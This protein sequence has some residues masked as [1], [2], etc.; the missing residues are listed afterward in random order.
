[1]LNEQHRAEARR[2]KLAE[3][4]RMLEQLR[5]EESKLQRIKQEKLAE[6]ERAGVPLKY[7]SDLIKFCAAKSRK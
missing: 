3:G 2:A 7:R 6:L 4:E 5:A 1:M